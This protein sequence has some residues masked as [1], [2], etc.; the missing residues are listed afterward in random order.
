[1]SSYDISR[2]YSQLK[3]KVQKQEK[4]E[5]ESSSSSVPVGK[6]KPVFSGT[7]GSKGGSTSVSARGATA[8]SAQSSGSS[9][10]RPTTAVAPASA[11]ISASSS[12]TQTTPAA[13]SSSIISASTAATHTPSGET[14]RDQSIRSSPSKSPSIVHRTASLSE[15]VHL[16]PQQPRPQHTAF[17]GEPTMGNG[18]SAANRKRKKSEEGKAQIGS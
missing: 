8:Q 4:K 5:T 1:M 10:T 9:G 18:A 15:T 12:A 16:T 14:P 11:S 17:V 13:A 2:Q 3:E 6:P 7:G